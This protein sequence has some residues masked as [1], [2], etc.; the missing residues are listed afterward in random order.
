MIEIRRLDTNEVIHSGNFETIKECL[1]DGVASGISFHKANLKGTDLMGAKLS[2]ANLSMADLSGADLKEI[3]FSEADLNEA[4]FNEAKNY[5]SFIAYDT[6]KRIVHCVRYKDTW[7]IKERCFWGT[8]NAL[9]RKVK[10]THN[11]R[12]YLSNIEIMRELLKE[13]K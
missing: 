2:K 7:M 9:E 10:A 8:L 12:V 3:N 13:R 5:Y 4:R 11:S 1:E 6:S